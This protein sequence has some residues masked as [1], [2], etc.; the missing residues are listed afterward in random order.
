MLTADQNKMWGARLGSIFPGT[1]KATEG[2]ISKSTAQRLLNT[3]VSDLSPELRGIPIGEL[4][5]KSANLPPALRP[6]VTPVANVPTGREAWTLGVG[7]VATGSPGATAHPG[8]DKARSPASMYQDAGD[9]KLH[10][11]FVELW[12]ERARYML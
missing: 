10:Q 9:A 8:N 6:R 1:Q 4:L 11:Q 5:L 3:K 12:G 2:S 7:F